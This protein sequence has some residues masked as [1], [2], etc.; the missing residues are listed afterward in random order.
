[1]KI[2]FCGGKKECRGFNELRRKRNKI[3]RTRDESFENDRDE[4][5]LDFL[6]ES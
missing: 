2:S 5:I 6:N 4:I 3:V 1:M